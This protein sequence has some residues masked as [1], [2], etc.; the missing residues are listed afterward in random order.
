MSPDQRLLLGCD[1]VKTAHSLAPSLH[2]LQCHLPEAD[3]TLMLPDPD[4]TELFPCSRMEI[5]SISSWLDSY[6]LQ[7]L[8]QVRFG[9]AILFTEPLRSPYTMSY[10]CYLAGIPVRLGQSIEFGGGVL[11]YCVTPIQDQITLENYHLHL[12]QSITSFLSS[13]ESKN[14]NLCH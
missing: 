4:G 5:K 7:W 6:T 2:H 9:I 14:G 8:S 12:T 10:L 13:R 1:T 11:S 3:M